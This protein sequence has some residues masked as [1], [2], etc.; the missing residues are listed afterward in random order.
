MGRKIMERSKSDPSVQT[1]EQILGKD[2]KKIVFYPCWAEKLGSI[3]AAIFLQQT[4]YWQCKTKDL[5]GWFYKTIKQFEEE[6][7]MSRYEQTTAIRVLMNHELIEVTVK[8][9]PPKRYF[10]LDYDKFME[11][12]R[13][14]KKELERKRKEKKEKERK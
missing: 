5:E 9:W 3:N 1:V 10:R 11:F 12:L 13:D 8:T 4:A 6:L 7:T 14:V 2:V